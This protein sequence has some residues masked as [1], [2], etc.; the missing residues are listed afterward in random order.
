MKSFNILQN[1][2]RREQEIIGK[3][4]L[5]PVLRGGKVKVKVGNIIWECPLESDFSG[6]GVFRIQKNRTALFVREA[7]FWEKEMYLRQFP[8]LSLV[9]FF[10]DPSGIWWARDLKRQNYVIVYLVEGLLPF[11]GI[12]AAFDRANYWY[13]GEDPKTDPRKSEALRNALENDIEP[14]NLKIPGLKIREH[15]LYEAAFNFK[16]KNIEFQKSGKARKIEKA[17]KLGNAELLDWVELPDGYRV[18]WKKGHTTLTSVINSKMS[19]VSAGLCLA[20]RDHEQD[21]TSLASLITGN[22]F[23]DPGFH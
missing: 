22:E 23:L 13:I 16:Q 2:I 15:E 1:I 14:G 21:L 12:S 6:W 8:K 10:L 4:F 19:V 5:A 18:R 3:E 9:L 11:D 20:G 17:L 7:E